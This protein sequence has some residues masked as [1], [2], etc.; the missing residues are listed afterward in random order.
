M[1]SRWRVFDGIVEDVDDGLAQNGDVRRNQN[2]LGWFHD[3]DLIF[4]FRQHLKMGRHLAGQG[5]E[6]YR[7]RDECHPSGI[8][9][10]QCQQALDQ[11]RQAISLFQHGTHD[12]PIGGLIVMLAQT[13][14]TNA[15]NDCERRSQFV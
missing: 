1:A 12:I 2:R 4:L 6:I 13:Y 8:G 7:A 14:L 15:A 11:Q 5:A 9:A 3:Q 10:R